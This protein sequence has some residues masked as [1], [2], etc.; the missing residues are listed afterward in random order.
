MDFDKFIHKCNHHHN[1]N[2][3]HFITQKVPDALSQSTSLFPIFHF[4]ETT[5]LPSI[6]GLLLLSQGF[7]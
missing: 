2:I 1:E 6:S 3:K 5:D 4:Q 7:I